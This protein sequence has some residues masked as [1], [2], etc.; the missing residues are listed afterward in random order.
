MIEL[1]GYGWFDDLMAEWEKKLEGCFQG[2]VHSRVQRH[3][4]RFT[5]GNLKRGGHRQEVKDMTW[6]I[7]GTEGFT[8]D[9]MK[10]KEKQWLKL[11]LESWDLWEI[12]REYNLKLFLWGDIIWDNVCSL[13]LVRLP[14]AL[15]EV[16]N[17]GDHRYGCPQQIIKLNS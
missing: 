12:M 14:S 3:N 17:L 11:Y 10:D 15:Y 9:G 8:Q 4:A 7:Q 6:G 13:I 1:F 2:M 5:L 16:F